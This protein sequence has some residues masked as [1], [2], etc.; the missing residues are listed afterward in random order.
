MNATVIERTRKTSTIA[1]RIEKLM[2]KRD[3]ARQTAVNASARAERLD[4][5]IEQL[6]TAAREAVAAAG[7][8]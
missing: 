7:R 1:E 5:Q 2:E 8:L 6:T 4:A 3:A